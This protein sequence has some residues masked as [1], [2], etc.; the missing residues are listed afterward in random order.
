MTMYNQ[1]SM[2]EN[3]VSKRGLTMRKIVSTLTL[4]A[5]ALVA[6]AIAHADT[7]S[8]VS[9]PGS[10]FPTPFSL[11]FSLPAS[12]IVVSSTPTVFNIPVSVVRNGS[13]DAT[14]IITFYTTAGGGGLSDND[15][16]LFPF[17]PQL[18]SGTTANP[19]F[20]LGT[21]N[22]SNEFAGGPTDYILTIAPNVTP[23]P[24]SLILLGTGVLGLAGAARRRFSK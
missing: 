8:L 4:F 6:P 9:V 11:S 19:T 18:F 16:P 20:L 2:T 5:A 14:D 22:L 24:S 15:S 13:T 10:T 21:F 7:F 17:G 23:E 1:S 3:F 12:P